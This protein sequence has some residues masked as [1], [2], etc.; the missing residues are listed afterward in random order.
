MAKQDIM[1]SA[2]GRVFSDHSNKF[3]L[4]WLLAQSKVDPEF[5]DLV[6]AAIPDPFKPKKRADIPRWYSTN[7]QAILDILRGN[8]AEP[9]M[10]GQIP[11]LPTEFITPESVEVQSYPHQ[12]WVT[13]SEVI[14]IV[15]EIL[16]K[17]LSGSEP[18]AVNRDGLLPM[19]PRSKQGRKENRV[20]SPIGTSIDIR[21]KVLFVQE[22]DRLRMT[23]SQLLDQIL[24]SYFQ[25]PKLSYE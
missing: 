20:H 12:Q 8:T 21:L 3:T 16:D 24:Y 7:K 5:H 23:Q 17:R 22:A 25:G 18:V 15:N 9:T 2:M 1:A 19:P 13:R 6:F 11:L 10:S 4:E 14:A